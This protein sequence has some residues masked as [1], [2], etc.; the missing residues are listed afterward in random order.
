MLPSITPEQGGALAPGDLVIAKRFH[1]EG[2]VIRVNVAKGLALVS[3]GMLQVEV[4]FNGLAL[5]P[6][7]ELPPK[8]ARETRPTPRTVVTSSV[9]ADAA[10]GAASSVAAA[11]SAQVEQAAMDEPPPQV[12]AGSGAPLAEEVPDRSGSS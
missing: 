4:P 1:R 7:K 2:K 6:P 11:S 10:S 5:P 9:T 3:V 8:P 12:V